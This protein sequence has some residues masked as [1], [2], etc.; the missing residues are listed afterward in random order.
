MNTE[1]ITALAIR[2]VI[3]S[4]WPAHASTLVN[5]I[6][7]SGQLVRGLSRKAE[8]KA[9]ESHRSIVTPAKKASQELIL[10]SFPQSCD[11][12]FLAEEDPD[13]ESPDPRLLSNKDPQGI[14]KGDVVVVD[15]LDGTSVFS[16]RH[17]SDWCVGG[18]VMHNGEVVSNI[19]TAPKANGGMVLFSAKKLVLFSEDG[20]IPRTVDQLRAKPHSETMILR[21]T[22]TELYANL[23]EMMPDVAANFLGVDTKGSGHFGL[24]DVALGRAGAIIQTP[25]KVWDWAPLYHAVTTVGGVFRFFRLVNNELVKVD[26]FDE[27]AFSSPRENRLGFIAGEPTLVDE[28]FKDLPQKGWKRREKIKVAAQ[29]K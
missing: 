9:G 15:P 27:R 29:G 16:S 11:L 26:A 13:K 12:K 7:E 14:F 24:M 1:Q 19:V 25:Q 22:D 21:G 23:L 8:A 6:C 20:S 10:K 5:A 4:G 3:D 18:A 2:L 28:L 17:S